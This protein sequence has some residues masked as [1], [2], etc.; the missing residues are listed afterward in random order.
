MH[1][2]LSELDLFLQ[3]YPSHCEFR[4]SWPI[5]GE[6]QV[7]LG[8]ASELPPHSV[9]SSILAIV[10]NEALEVLFLY[11]EERC[12]SISQILIG[13]RPEAGETVFE[14]I[15]REVQEETGWTVLPVE[16]I[17]YRHFHQTAPRSEKSDRPYPDFVQPIFSARTVRNEQRLALPGHQMPCGMVAWQEVAALL[18]CDQ[19][20]LLMTAIDSVRGTGSTK[21]W[22]SLA[23]T[24]GV[25]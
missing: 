10:L 2:S 5:E 17:G 9:S 25:R 21:E 12:G 8:S 18:P 22:P 6:M 15:T 11:P 14:T 16:V 7:R 1:R 4:E 24:P 20:P 3:K 13:G 23:N 19:R